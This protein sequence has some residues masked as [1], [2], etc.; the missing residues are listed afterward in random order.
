[1]VFFYPASFYF[2]GQLCRFYLKLSAKLVNQT[3]SPLGLGDSRVKSWEEFGF[4]D[5]GQ[6]PA[7]PF[8]DSAT[9]EIDSAEVASVTAGETSASETVAAASEETDIVEG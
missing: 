2:F 6:L 3:I 5:S 9:Q 1:M 4:K 8:T 7:V